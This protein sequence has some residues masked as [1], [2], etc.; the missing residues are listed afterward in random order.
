MP[1]SLQ[2]S[3]GVHTHSGLS[4]GRE[5]QDEEDAKIHNAHVVIK[6]SFHSVFILFLSHVSQAEVLQWFESE[7]VEVKSS[8]TLCDPMDYT[9]H[10]I[11]QVR[12]LEWVAFPFSR[13][14]SQPRD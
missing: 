12:R 6:N 10:G 7:S 14:S 5:T 3:Y 8:P 13:G 9:V 1:G 11:L 2:R 4:W